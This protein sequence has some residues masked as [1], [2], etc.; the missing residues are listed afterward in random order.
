MLATQSKSPLKS[1]TVW[2]GAGAVVIGLLNL[3]AWLTAPENAAE[4]GELA[5]GVVATVSGAIAIYGR[6]K[7]VAK[8]AIGGV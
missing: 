6:I 5:T 8:V 2:G 4:V 3:L 1:K 7:A